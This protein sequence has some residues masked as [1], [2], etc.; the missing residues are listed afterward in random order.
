M[1][2]LFYSNRNCL[3]HKIN[4]CSW[5]G[6][7]LLAKLIQAFCGSSVGD[8]GSVFQWRTTMWAVQACVF[9]AADIPRSAIHLWI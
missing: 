3:R 4:D 1:R 2:A 9:A 8:Q 5:F 7:A 6:G